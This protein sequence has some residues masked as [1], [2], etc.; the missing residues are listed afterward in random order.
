MMENR[1]LI[2]LIKKQTA[3]EN[4]VS[5]S[6]EQQLE[7]VNTAAARLLL[8][9]MKFDA[10]KHAAILQGILDVIENNSGKQLWD[11]KI[12]A[13]VDKL[14]VKKELD[15]HITIE[16]NTL[17]MAKEEI[18]HT[19]DEG[20]KLLLQHIAE[21]EDRH[22]ALLKTIVDNSYKINP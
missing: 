18:K 9:E 12:D 20:I 2:E 7:M 16:K 17:E 6:V 1:K 4:E 14:V 10:K 5:K 13:Y 19:D 21:D 15:K 22:H 11:C 3:I 8:T